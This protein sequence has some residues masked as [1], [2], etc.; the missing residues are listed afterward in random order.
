MALKGY[1]YDVICDI[2]GVSP[3][4]I[5]QWKK[6]YNQAYYSCLTPPPAY[7]GHPQP[8]YVQPQPV[9]VQPQVIYL[10]PLGSPNWN[11]RCA[12]K[13]RSFV[14]TGPGTPGYYTGFDYAQHD[15]SLP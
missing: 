12:Q 1:L 5:S 7:V 3:G 8:V 11:Y 14:A 4:Y 10:P 9:Y 6:A 13:Y 15:C 2:L